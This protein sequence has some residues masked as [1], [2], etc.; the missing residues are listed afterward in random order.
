MRCFL[1]GWGGSCAEVRRP[2]GQGDAENELQSYTTVW[3]VLDGG[4]CGEPPTRPWGSR[5]RPGRRPLGEGT[6]QLSMTV[7]RFPEDIGFFFWRQR[8]RLNKVNKESWATGT[9]M[10]NSKDQEEYVHGRDRHEMARVKCLRP[11]QV[12]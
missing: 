12:T 8:E 2:R 6:F 3:A 11:G 9:A 1:S 7:S 4:G 10:P 5:K